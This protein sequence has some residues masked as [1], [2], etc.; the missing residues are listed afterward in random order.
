M[1]TLYVQLQHPAGRRRPAD[2]SVP[3]ARALADV[4][5][6]TAT[7]RAVRDGARR[8]RRGEP[9]LPSCTSTAAERHLGAVGR[10]RS[11]MQRAPGSSRSPPASWPTASTLHLQGPRLR[12]RPVERRRARA[13]RDRQRST[14]VAPAAPTRHLA[15]TIPSD[16]KWHKGEDQAGQPSPLSPPAG[17]PTLSRL[18]VGAGQDA[19]PRASTPPTAT[20]T[21]RRSRRPP[22]AGTCCRSASHRQG[23]QRVA[24]RQVH[25]QRR[26]G[27]P[28]LAG[29]GRRRSSA[30]SG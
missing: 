8:R 11:P 3:V 21:D 5:P 7:P 4:G 9:G 2:A 23:R 15:R 25:L 20:T 19:R 29:R 26:P 13:G 28:H 17:D 10:Q 18:R 22:T 6:P 14:P 30:G 27:R 12:R 24:G 16:G 1:P